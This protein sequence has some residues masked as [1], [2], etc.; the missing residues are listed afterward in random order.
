[1]L[2]SAPKVEP[3]NRKSTGSPF[4]FVWGMGSFYILSKIF[5]WSLSTQDSQ[6]S[7]NSSSYNYVI[8]SIYGAVGISFLILGYCFWV[9]RKD[10]KS[11]Q[12]YAIEKNKLRKKHP[13]KFAR[14]EKPTPKS[15]I[16]SLNEE[17]D[18]LQMSFWEWVVYCGVNYKPSSLQDLQT[19]LQEVEELE[20]KAK[21]KKYRYELPKRNWKENRSQT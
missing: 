16:P 7:S 2:K 13:Q 10:F 6:S 1:M 3:L 11:L 4:G 5:G 19:K 12:Q 17:P 9:L 18:I 20:A 21:V 14:I 15:S 8:Y